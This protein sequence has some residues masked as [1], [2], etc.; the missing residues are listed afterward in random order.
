MATVFCLAV[1]SNA[2]ADDYRKVHIVHASEQGFQVHTA[3]ENGT[4]YYIVNNG[5]AQAVISFPADYP[6]QTASTWIDQAGAHL[7]LQF[8]SGSGLGYGCVTL[9][10]RFIN[11]T[12]KSCVSAPCEDACMGCIGKPVEPQTTGT[13]DFGPGPF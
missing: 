8:P 5:F 1:I 7:E 12:T 3:T 2:V 6:T 9:W 11:L 10:C 4:N 13:M